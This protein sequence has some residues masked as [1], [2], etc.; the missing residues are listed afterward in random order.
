VAERILEQ[1][2]KVELSIQCICFVDFLH[3]VA[4]GNKLDDDTVT[5]TVDPLSSLVIHK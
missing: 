1:K 2:D 4:A 3:Q 5:A